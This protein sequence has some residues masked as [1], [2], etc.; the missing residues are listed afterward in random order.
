MPR[1]SFVRQ[2]ARS[3]ALVFR[4][5]LDIFIYTCGPF[6]FCCCCCCTPLNRS[7][8]RR[9]AASPTTTTV[10]DHNCYKNG[11]V[12]WSRY[13]M[14][15]GWVYWGEMAARPPPRHPS[16]QIRKVRSRSRSAPHRPTTTT[17]TNN[18]DVARPFLFLFSYSWCRWLENCLCAR[19]FGR[20]CRHLG[21]RCESN[22]SSGSHCSPAPQS[23]F[24]SLSLS[25]SLFVCAPLFLLLLLL[26]TLFMHCW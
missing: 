22:C 25:R 11:V 23:L 3:L 20:A 16:P 6:S 26:S 21:F 14:T 17:T 8:T 5:L 13:A 12:P 18:K 1:R 15:G 24:L 19:A 7:R 9:E 4:L 10:K 2:C